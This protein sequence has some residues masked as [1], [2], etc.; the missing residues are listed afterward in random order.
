MGRRNKASAD[1]KKST[2]CLKFDKD[3][4]ACYYEYK[5]REQMNIKKQVKSFVNYIKFAYFLSNGIFGSNSPETILKLICKFVSLE[6]PFYSNKVVMGRSIQKSIELLNILIS[7]YIETKSE[8]T[9]EQILEVLKRE[10]L[11]RES[12]NN[13]RK[14][15]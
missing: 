5:E 9:L 14:Q 12:K 15:F 1:T 11:Q 6:A 4:H 13:G 10:F 7:S 8:T 3:Q 2:S